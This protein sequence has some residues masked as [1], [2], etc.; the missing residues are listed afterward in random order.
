[1]PG[2]RTLH[3]RYGL[4]VPLP[5][6]GAASRIKMQ[7]PQ[8]AVLRGARLIIID[9]GPTAAK[10]VYDAIDE[11][12]KDVMQHDPVESAKP[13][14]GKVVLIGGA[15][16]Q[17]P[18][19]I[20]HGTRVDVARYYIRRSTIWRG[21]ALH[22]LVENKRAELDPGWEARTLPTMVGGR[23]VG[24]WRIACSRAPKGIKP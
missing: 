6:E 18:P 21:V 15:F 24:L 19:V 13:F 9:E 4:P 23:D 2:G 7:S 12:L 1:M 20:R 8:A 10:A 16:R 3:S 17:L 11:L 22:S 14:G 5:L